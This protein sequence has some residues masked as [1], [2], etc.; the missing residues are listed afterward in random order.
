MK[1]R[2]KIIIGLLILSI[3]IGIIY[4]RTD[5]FRNKDNLINRLQCLLIDNNTIELMAGESEISDFEIYLNSDNI[6]FK[7]GKM[8]GEIPREYGGINFLIYYRNQLIGQAGIHNRNWWQTHDFIFDF[9]SKNIDKFEFRVNGPD[10]RTLYYKH[11]IYDSVNLI[12]T[13]V[14][15][16]KSGLSGQINKSYYDQT[17]CLIA[18][19]IWINDTLISMNMY[20]KGELLK[21]YSARKYVKDTKYELIKIDTVGFLTYNWI[22]VK[23]DTTLSERIIIKN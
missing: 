7:N 11:I 6:V 12:Q 23:L 2:N 15:Y 5:Y 22:T 3:V 8:T 21:N 10:S 18:D 9:S 20:D 13:E 17:K 4:I 16:N 19:E 14:F 1:K